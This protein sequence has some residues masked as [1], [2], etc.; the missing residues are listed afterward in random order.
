MKTI[1]QDLTITPS[2]GNVFVDLGFDEAEAAVLAMR[3]KLMSDIAKQIER[4]RWTQTE[5]ARRFGI[6]QARVSDL[7]R[8]KFDKFS[9]DMLAQLATRAG[10]RVVLEF[11]EAA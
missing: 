10:N 6:S 2:S 3:A 5:S 1:D 7:V 9:L 4:N 8:G 11:A